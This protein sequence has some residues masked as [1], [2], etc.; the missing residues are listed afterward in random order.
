MIKASF[1]PV[2]IE[3]K[4]INA[5]QKYQLLDT[6]QEEQFDDITKMA[7]QIC[8]TRIALISFL[9]TDRQWIKS[10]FGID[11]HE[12]PRD[13]S[14]CAYTIL[15][16]DIF[17]VEDVEKDKRFCVNPLFIN[18]PFVRFYAGVP[19]TTPTG[20][21]IGT[22]CVMDSEKKTLT[23]F[24]RK[25]LKYLATHVENLLKLKLKDLE[26]NKIKTQYHDL[27]KMA[28]TG[29]WMLDLETQNT[30][31]SDAIYEI[32]QIPKGT[33][34]NKVNGMSF[35]A[36]HERDRLSKLINS[37]IENGNSFDA[38][39]EFYDAYGVHKWVRSIGEALYDQNN[40]IVKVL[41]T[42]QDISK[43]KFA[44][45]AVI[46]N[47]RKLRLRLEQSTDAIM[48][49]EAPDWYFTSAN[50]A[51]L[52]LFKA[53]S[54][55]EFCKLGPWSI[56]P[57]TQPNGQNSSEE[58]K[59]MIG[60][61]LLNNSHLFN[62]THLSLDG[63]EIPCIV[64]L[65]KIT[66]D[67]KTYLQ[68]TVRDIT[69]QKKQETELIESKLE[70]QKTNSYL[71]FALEGSNLGIWDW[72]LIDNSVKFDHRW[73]SMLGLNVKNIKMELA[74]WSSLV[75]PDDLA[76]C[77]EALTKY[78]EGKT[79][80]Y[81]NVHRMK[82]ADGRWVYILD[83]GKYSLF[84]K[85]G[86]PI[87]FTG[88]HLDI[89]SQKIQE[90]IVKE[91][92]DFRAQ[93]MS[94]ANN[95]KQVFDYV[96]KRLI[97]LT[98]S[99]YGYIGEVVENE[100]RKFVHTLAISDDIED[101][102]IKNSFDPSSKNFFFKPINNEFTKNIVALHNYIIL[103]ISN[104]NKVIAVIGLTTLE[105]NVTEKQIYTFMSLIN[106]IGEI[107][108]N[109]QIKEQLEI[110]K[111]LSQHN[112]KLAS[113]GELASGVGHEINNPLAIIDGQIQLMEKSL[114]D[115]NHEA[116]SILSRISKIKINI[117]RISNIIKGLRSFARSDNSEYSEFDVNSMIQETLKMLQELYHTENI[118]IIFSE[119]KKCLKLKGNRGKLQ[120]VIV[121][122]MNNAKDSTKEK[123]E[124][125]IS[126]NLR[127][128]KNCIFIEITDNGCGIPESIKEKI[129]QPFYTTKPIGQ[130]TGIGLSISSSI[131]KEF[132]GHI[133][134]ESQL[135]I[136]TKF[137]IIIPT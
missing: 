8:E 58:A 41:G 137:K 63:K 23:D 128:H 19:L 105:K 111:T 10:R 64:L 101:F 89:T 16:H 6:P 33:P 82:H 69:L 22:L 18:A 24:Q 86:E 43:R 107:V 95:K 20:E 34:T 66:E 96:I 50:A 87:Q 54:E 80:I 49:I 79:P 121:N 91:I 122:L 72:N 42:F 13:I 84:N 108:E 65:S 126:L 133:E 39:F 134:L 48:T 36:A 46:K 74:T 99:Q 11:L 127:E 9:D 47:E 3:K 100:M 77:Y 109:F 70:L 85:E 116:S 125:L 4:R 131:V 118:K 31:W 60:L 59:K 115:K 92:S 26:F 7:A 81:E 56:S 71:D 25:T 98:H 37:C 120:Q 135:G 30:T 73:A 97:D 93:F 113:L 129:F 130:G 117:E 45:Q 75:H 29:D 119:E 14:F 17:I 32:Y 106:T 53:N 78:R 90:L 57:T 44:E 67:D 132:H 51:T 27:Q 104:A 55:L 83:K 62:W 61:A 68:A 114:Q 94:A 52:N 15:S 40:K 28:Q 35:Y 12:T 136:G 102:E 76:A 2:L 123:T 38:E 5:L 110:Q 1:P 88:T 112:A 103:P 21:R 124:R